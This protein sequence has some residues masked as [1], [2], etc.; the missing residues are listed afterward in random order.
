[1]KPQL[2]EYDLS[3]LSYIKNSEIPVKG[4][5]LGLAFGHKD[6]RAERAAIEKLRKNGYPICIAEQGG[7]FYSENFRD[8]KRTIDDINSRINEMSEVCAGMS[9]GLRE[10][11]V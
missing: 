2:T 4:R 3:V 6:N 9:M 11:A 10:K 7:Y 8:I 5:Q 1:M